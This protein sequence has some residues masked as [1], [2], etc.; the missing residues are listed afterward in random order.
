MPATGP[1]VFTIVTDIDVIAA[2]IEAKMELLESALV[3]K[4]DYV[5]TLLQQ[6]IQ[7]KLQGPVLNVITGKLLRSVEVIPAVSDGATVTGSVQAGGGAAFYGRFQEE[8]T[9]PYDIIA[10]KARVLAFPIGGEMIFRKSVHHP[11]LPARS[12]VG[13]TVEEQRAAIVAELQATPAEV[14][15]S[16]P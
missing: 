11:G 10:T 12:F 14:A 8:G 13:S 15:A 3:Q 1:L 2:S 16:N 5:D 6:G 7:E 4:V 9:G